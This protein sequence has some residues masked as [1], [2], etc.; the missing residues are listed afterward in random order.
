MAES[1]DGFIVRG[2]EALG[3]RECVTLSTCA[4]A[5]SAVLCDLMEN[6]LEE[7]KVEDGKVSFTAKPF[8]IIT[9]KFK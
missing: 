9:V 8:E 7:L 4:G 6:E 5:K 2:Y 1:A 3:D